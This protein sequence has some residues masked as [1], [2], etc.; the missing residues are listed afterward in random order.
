M[1]GLAS[2]GDQIHSEN[3]RKPDA[4]IQSGSYEEPVPHGD[5]GNYEENNC[6]RYQ[7]LLREISNVQETL[8]ERVRDSDAKNEDGQQRL[9]GPS[10]YGKK[11]RRLISEREWLNYMKENSHRRPGLSSVTIFKIPGFLKD[12]KWEAYVP[13]RISLG[14]FHHG[15]AE[16]IA[17]DNYKGEALRNMMTR[18]NRDK[19]LPGGDETFAN[20][21]IDAI[22]TVEKD[23]RGCYE[24]FIDCNE[25]TLARMLCL[26]GCFILEVLK[27]LDKRRSQPDRINHPFFWGKHGRCIQYPE[28]HFDARKSDTVDR[29][30]KVTRIGERPGQQFRDDSFGCDGEGYL[31]FVQN[32]Q[33]RYSCSIAT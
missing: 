29:S 6:A 19:G 12:T 25:I 3:K 30:P 2:P 13:Q 31:W 26:D 23:I 24:E 8:K 4:E 5:S 21:A 17:M 11:P 9:V 33:R 16:L 10:L 7:V 14:P 22:L 18:F 20:S 27:A 1:S 15:T 32:L 28:G